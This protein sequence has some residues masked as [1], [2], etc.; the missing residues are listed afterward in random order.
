MRI[1]VTG[2][3]GFIFSNFIRYFLKTHPNDQIINLDKLTYCG[4]LEN[5]KDFAKNK[6]YT[7]IKGDITDKNL[8]EQVVK[9]CDWIVNGAAESHVDRAITGPASFVKTNIFGTFVLLEAA[10]KYKIKKFV[11]IGTDEEY[12]S[13]KRGYF[14]ED[15]PLNPSS[16]YSASKAA[17]SLLALSYFKTYQLPV[18]IV[19]ST[20]NFGPYQ[21]PEKIIPLFVTNLLEGKKVPL[22]GRGGNKRNWLYVLDNCRAIDLVLHKGRP[23]QIYNVAGKAELTNLELTKLILKELNKDQTWIE[24]VRDRP[25]HDW[26]YAVNDSKIKRLGWR[27]IYKFK[28]ALKETIRWYQENEWWWKPIKTGE[29]LRYYQKQYNKIS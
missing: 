7:F 18:V 12:G 1:L 11:Q 9:R 25:G 2:G 4:R 8:V 22:Y 15:S 27:P 16:V 19:R 5:T 23:G 17:A 24:F 6:N 26:R 3:A 20:N 10:R 13:I 29:F 14:K 21:Y 28:K